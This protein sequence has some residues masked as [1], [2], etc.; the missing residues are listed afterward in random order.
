MRTMFFLTLTYL[1]LSA[2]LEWTN[3]V[4]G[5]AIAAGVMALIPR[6]TEDRECR[7]VVKAVPAVFQ[8]GAILGYDLVK[9]GIQVARIVLNPALPIQPG[10]VAVSADCHS[11]LGRALSAHAMTL[12]PGQL[13]VGIDE[14]GVMYTHCL[15][16]TGAL[17]EMS[18]AQKAR[19]RLLHRIFLSPP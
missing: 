16:V 15:D 13:V 18:K 4:L 2:N 11:D 12:T 1:V 6:L 14:H 7:G 8:Y 3:I 5:A 9:S 10:I 19:E 17:E